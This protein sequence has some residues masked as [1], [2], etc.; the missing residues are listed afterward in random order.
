MEVN[1]EEEEEDEEED[2]RNPEEYEKWK[3]RFVGSILCRIHFILQRIGS[4]KE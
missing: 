3:L 4:Y 2:L 1:S